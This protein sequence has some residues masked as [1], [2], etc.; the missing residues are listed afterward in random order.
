MPL[1]LGWVSR[2]SLLPVENLWQ[3]WA[4]LQVCR[5]SCRAFHPSEF[6]F[7][8][9]LCQPTVL[10]S[11]WKRQKKQKSKFTL[12]GV[13]EMRSQVLYWAAE[14]GLFY[15]R[16]MSSDNTCICYLVIC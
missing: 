12:S 9:C 16:S 2:V 13:N 14:G 4:G 10:L 6:R 5:H 3:G 8:P 1:A 7:L 15:I 11:G